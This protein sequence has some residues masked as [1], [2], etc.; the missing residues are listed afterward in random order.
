MFYL[1][2]QEGV[3]YMYTKKTFP[4]NTVKAHPW[5][6]ILKN[7]IPLHVHLLS[8]HKNTETLNYVVGI[9]RY[10]NTYHQLPEHCRYGSGFLGESGW[11]HCDYYHK[12]YALWGFPG[13]SYG[14]ESTC[15]V[16]DL[17]SIPGS[18]ISPVEGN[19][20]PFQYSC[21]ENSMDRGAW[22]ATVQGVEKSQ[23]C[24]SD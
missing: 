7:F 18:G 5:W 10:V 16:G 20:Y 24:L 22:R 21:L 2:G 3:H 11:F 6:L 23:T 19:G 17:D 8:L 4:Q 1:C 13:G 12:P 15:N 9:Q 14:K